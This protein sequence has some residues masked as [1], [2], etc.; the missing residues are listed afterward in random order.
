MLTRPPPCRR[1]HMN[2]ETT[3]KVTPGDHRR[4]PRP[5]A[6]EAAAPPPFPNEHGDDGVGVSRL[7]VVS[8]QTGRSGPNR[9][10]LDRPPSPQWTVDTLS[11]VA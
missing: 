2:T 11:Q 4:T 6:D 3:D 9:W 1:S 8:V 10:T 7:N 5:Y